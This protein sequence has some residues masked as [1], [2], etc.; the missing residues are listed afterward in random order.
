MAQG[1]SPTKY[2]FSFG[3]W[4]ISTG[5]DPFGPPARKEMEFARKIKAYKKLGFDAVQFHDDDI[6]PADLDWPN[7][8][9][10]VAAVKSMLEGEGLFVEIVAP[11]LW[12]DPR[13]LDTMTNGLADRDENVRATAAWALGRLED[14]D[15]VG[16]LGQVVVV[17]R[18]ERHDDGFA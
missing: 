9:K 2:Q 7:T 5:A 8:L 3:P 17:D 16:P 11:R 6:V 10:G 1:V 4:N 12:E 14:I 18:P 15:A 13:T